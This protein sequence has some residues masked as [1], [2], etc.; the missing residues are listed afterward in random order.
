MIP[1][2]RK[3]THPG[4]ILREE[5]LKSKGMTQSELSVRVGCDPALINKIIHGHCRVT[6]KMAIK[7]SRVFGTS[8]DFWVHAQYAVD[9]YQARKRMRGR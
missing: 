9:L 4:E 6:I 3:P 8:M 5:F 2:N 1:K 7:L